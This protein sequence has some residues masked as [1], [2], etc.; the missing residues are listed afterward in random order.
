MQIKNRSLSVGSIFVFLASCFY[1]F[2]AMAVLAQD[3]FYVYG[4]GGPYPAMKE[5]AE[6]FSKMRSLKMEITAGPTNKWIEKAKADAHLI[7]SGAEYMMTD[8]IRAMEGRIDETSITPLYLRPSAILVRPGIPKRIRDFPDLLKP[9]MK[10]MVVEGAGQTG[11]WEDM[12]GKQGS[13]QTVRQLRKNI[14]KFA[15]NSA[16]AKKIWGG[17]ADID[18]WLIWNIWQVANP[19][20]ADLV[21][22]SS[23]YVIYR[24]CGIALT[25]RGKNSA[26]AK[27]FIDFLTSR[28]G[29][30][31][32]A[33]WGWITPSADSKPIRVQ[34]NIRVV[35]QIKDDDW[36]K[37][38][39][40]G[41]AYVKRL[42]E[43]YRDMGIPGNEIHINAVFHGAAG[44]WMLKDAS[45]R[46][47]KKKDEPNPNKKIINDLIE[48]GISIELCAQTMKEHGWIAEDILPKV[49]I[50]LGA[51]PRIIDLQLQ[52]YAYI[53]F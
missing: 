14:V 40:K 3:T 10:V 50:V 6:T 38:I 17:N 51:Y 42:I 32:F 37:D 39:G 53:R 1:L 19:T 44:Y 13:I 52:G 20:L 5:A 24:D 29:E 27:E 48:S 33:K 22:V 47:F 28:Q 43:T 15:A 4:P 36:Q 7:Y 9:G 16:E 34:N 21:K 25:K 46:T 11:L 49:K 23:N 30:G 41:L 2:S 45:Y 18:A 35:Y 26:V 31:I 8:F 12:A